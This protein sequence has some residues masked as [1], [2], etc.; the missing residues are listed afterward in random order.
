MLS[1]CNKCQH[2]LDAGLPAGG[3][4]RRVWQPDICRTAPIQA[5]HA[6]CVC[7]SQG[8][9]QLQRQ[10]HCVAAP[11]VHHH[12]PQSPSS[13][14]Q[15]RTQSIHASGTRNMMQLKLCTR[16]WLCALLPSASFVFV[17]CGAKP[18]WDAD[19]T[20]YSC[21]LAQQHGSNALH[22]QE[23]QKCTAGAMWQ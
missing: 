22:L 4:R 8:P 20:C 15:R 17:H 12:H 16:C 14:S 5:L 19:Q 1:A 23:L 9:P 3:C 10:A 7:P 6:Q 21:R 13:D 2:E 11:K 18:S